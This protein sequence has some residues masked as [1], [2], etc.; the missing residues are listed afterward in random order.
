MIENNLVED[1]NDNML[2]ESSNNNDL[3]FSRLIKIQEL[4]KKESILR[5]LCKN[6]YIIIFNKINISLNYS[7]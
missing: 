6:I 7:Y 3:S 2:N 5:E 1:Q 4:I